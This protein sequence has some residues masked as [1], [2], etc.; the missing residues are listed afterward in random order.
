M[1]EKTPELETFDGTGGSPN[2]PRGNAK[3]RNLSS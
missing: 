1:L 2:C 3:V